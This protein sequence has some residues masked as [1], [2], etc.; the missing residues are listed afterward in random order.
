MQEK[1]HV[2][3]RCTWKTVRIMCRFLQREPRGRRP[4]HPRGAA[5][6]RA[7]QVCAAAHSEV[8]QEL[9]VSR[10]VVSIRPLI[11]VVSDV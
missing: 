9:V 11:V 6:G 1:S 3:Y 5:A 10:G 4:G 7:A 2:N 8:S